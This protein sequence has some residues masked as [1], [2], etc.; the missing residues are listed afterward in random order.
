MALPKPPP[1]KL[2]VRLSAMNIFPSIFNGKHI[3]IELQLCGE[4]R[5]SAHISKGQFANFLIDIFEDDEILKYCNDEILTDEQIKTKNKY[6]DNN[7]KY[8]Y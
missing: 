3:S 1:V 5:T 2:F 6:F 7:G 4:I 8:I